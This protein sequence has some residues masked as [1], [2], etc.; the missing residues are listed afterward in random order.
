MEAAIENAQE[1]LLKYLRKTCTKFVILYTTL[2]ILRIIIV[3]PGYF[4]LNNSSINTIII[5]NALFFT[6]LW[7]ILEVVS[8]VI[9]KRYPDYCKCFFLIIILMTIE[10]II[11]VYNKIVIN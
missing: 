4:F 11:D 5:W 2:L 8:F 9:N 10:F 1:F 6:I 7:E 3:T